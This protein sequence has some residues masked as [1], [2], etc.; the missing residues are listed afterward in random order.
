MEEQERGKESSIV[1]GGSRR[2]RLALKMKI[3]IVSQEGRKI[4]EEKLG[5]LHIKFKI[6]YKPALC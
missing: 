2:G 5:G 1:K 4:V 3:H 6:I